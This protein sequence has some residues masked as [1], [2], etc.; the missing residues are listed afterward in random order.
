MDISYAA[1]DAEMSDSSEKSVQ[2]KVVKSYVDSAITNLTNEMVA[3]EKIH[4]AAYSD[5]NSRLAALEA[6]L[7]SINQ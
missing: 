7:S 6:A 5:L 4:A 1:S 3:N 2:N